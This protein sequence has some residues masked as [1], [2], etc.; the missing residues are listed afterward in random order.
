MLEYF[1]SVIGH[2]LLLAAHMLRSRKIVLFSE[3]IMSTEK[4]P[5]CC[6]YISQFSKLRVLRKRF[7]GY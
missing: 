6:L 2:Y 1:N 7:E 3:Q 5:S 4:Y